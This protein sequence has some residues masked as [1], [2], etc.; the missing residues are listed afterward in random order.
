[1]S[2]IDYADGLNERKVSFALFRNALH[3]NDL[4]ASLG[5]ERTIDKLVE[6]LKSE[7]TSGKYAQGLE[8]VYIDLT[9][10]GNKL[11]RVYNLL[12]EYDEIVK[13]FKLNILEEDTLYDDRFPLPL[14]HDDLVNAPLDINCVDF[15]ET[16]S[17]IWFVFCSKQYVIE[18]EILP[19]GSLT[20]LV[21]EDYGRFDEIFGIRKR[22][23]QLFDVVCIDKESSILEFRMDGLDVQRA[24]DIERRLEF[25][26]SKI[27]KAFES[28]FD[29]GELFAGPINLFPAI[30]KLYL[31]PDG[32]IAEIGHTTTSAGVHNGKMRTKQLDF[33]DDRYHVGG[34]S[35]VAELNPH[36]LS[37]CWD[38]P[39]GYGYVQLVVPGTV[40]LTSSENPT[41]DTAHILSCAS[42][43]DYDFVMSKLLESLM[44]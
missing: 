35:K 7:K 31:S 11:V 34:V 41:I 15:Y 9:N 20:D 44:P 5:W 28:D 30:Q 25:L 24:K 27:L 38:S 19:E 17:R 18:K 21:I 29:L 33:R 23:V 40:A 16:D 2:A 42:D 36:M 13:F 32:R 12:G 10:N 14:E 43:L 3:Q 6:Y 22:A 1:M 4:A 39:S 26:E 8:D 37:K